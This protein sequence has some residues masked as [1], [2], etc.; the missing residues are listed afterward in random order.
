MNNPNLTNWDKIRTTV[1]HYIWGAYANG[2][3]GAVTA[4]YAFVGLAVGSTMDPSK[5]PPPSWHTLG[6]V[7][8]VRFG[9]DVL[10]YFKA[11]PLPETFPSLE[12]DF[13]P[14][15]LPRVPVIVEQPVPSSPAMAIDP[16]NPFKK[17]SD[18]KA[19]P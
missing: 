10:G 13:P 2:F 18:S 16:D 1:L 3:N 7:F 9:L 11:H 5:I 17:L 15:P 6:F 12:D 19:A 8:S 4:L 14:L